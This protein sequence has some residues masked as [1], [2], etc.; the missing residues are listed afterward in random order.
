V[1]LRQREQ[2]EKEAQHQRELEQARHLAQTQRQRALLL[3]AGL[4]VAVVLG[5]LSFSLYRQS[6]SNLANAQTA[7]TQAAENLQSAQ[8]NAATATHALGLSEQRGTE[9]ARNAETAQANER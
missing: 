1:S 7:N 4:L 8:Q 3:L 5:L 9:S 2:A 6:S